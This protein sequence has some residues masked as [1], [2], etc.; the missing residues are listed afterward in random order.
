VRAGPERRAVPARP[1]RTA[2]SAPGPRS[3]NDLPGTSGFVTIEDTLAAWLPAQ[4]WYA[5]SGTAIRDLRIAADTMLAPG[6]PALR[7]L[8]ITLSQGGETACYQVLVGVRSRLPDHLRHAVI[9][10][11]DGGVAYDGL[12][13]PALTRTLLRSLADQRTVGP[14]RFIREPGT[15]IGAAPDGV[16]LTA[17]Q[18]NTSVTFG[19]VAILKVLR[20]IFPGCNP[21]LEVASALAR[22]GSRHVAEPF[23]WIETTMGGEPT[24]LA[25]LSR[26]LPR[27]RD[28]WLLATASLSAAYRA[29]ADG[30]R[31]ADAD[32]DRAADADGEQPPAAHADGEQPPASHAYGDQPALSHA[33]GDQSALSHAESAQPAAALARTGPDFSGEAYLLGTAT[34]EVHADLAAAFGTG[35]LAPGALGELAAEMISKLEHACA[36]VPELRKHEEKVRGCYARLADVAAPV[37][38]QRVHG[39]YHLGQVLRTPDGWVALDFEGEPVTPLAQR[40]GRAPAL[41]DV[42]GMLRSFDYAARHLLLGRPDRRALGRAAAAWVRRSR[43]A[44]C[45]GYAQAGGMDPRSNATLLQALL[46]EKAVYE[47]VYEATHRPSW[48]PIPLEWIAATLWRRREPAWSATTRSTASSAARITTRT[49]S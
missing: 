21:D 35:E 42:A 2:A 31:A 49:Q 18:S 46:L 36:E 40:R 13:D 20:R 37:P 3:P 4:R 8:I 41:R 33:Y 38:V 29:A 5:G 43:E 48:L 19:D 26:Y 30:D 47:V 28:G 6:D 23:G 1:A 11:A 39:D 25:V 34:A 7:H 10:P 44:F 9:G 14:L 17:E 45:D 32:G 27:A 22:R 24:L 16:V 12:H 15:V